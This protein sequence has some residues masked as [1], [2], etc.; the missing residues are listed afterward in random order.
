MAHLTSERY[1][2]AIRG[3]HTIKTLV[4]VVNQSYQVLATLDVTQGNISVDTSNDI[5][6]NCTIT[7]ADY[8]NNL[9]PNDVTDLLHPIRS[10]MLRVYRGVQFND[11]TDE[12]FS[13]G[14]FEIF[15]ADIQDNGEH[16]SV[17]IRGFDLAKRI[18]RARLDRNYVVPAGTRYDYAIRDLIFFAAGTHSIN[19]DSTGNMVT[20]DLV[21]GASGDQVG[22]DPWKYCQEMA[23]S[24]GFELFFDIV[25]V[26][27]LR[28]V[29]TVAT[30]HPAM[31]IHDD[32]ES[33]L[34][35]V[36]KRLR[37]DN[38]FNKVIATGENSAA[39]NPVR[40][41]AVDNNP[42]SPTYYYGPYGQVPT[43]FRSP[44]IMTTSQ[45]QQ[46]AEARLRQVIGIS[47]SINFI[48][49]PN[50]ALEGGDVIHLERKR[51]GIDTALVVDKFNVNLSPQQSMN[52]SAREVGQL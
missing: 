49:T 13:L 27:R 52:I 35:N 36:D 43:F 34:L 10:N 11:G 31:H 46:V 14:V 38:T 6:R 18:Q 39:D 26:C 23:Q 45:A 30:G 37:K 21:F 16:L 29:P 32:D 25:G 40:G 3:S 17:Q 15:D 48:I 19:F 24:I 1:Q 33:V 22:G 42:T 9:T 2:R 41:E 47:S 7:V 4:Q 28:P 51:A 8:N 50:P 20:P 12:M 5:R 44:Y